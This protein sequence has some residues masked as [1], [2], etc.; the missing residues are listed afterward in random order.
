MGITLAAYP[1]ICKAPYKA[2]MNIKIYKNKNLYFI[3]MNII[4]VLK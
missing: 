2:K 1:P 3:K 4:T